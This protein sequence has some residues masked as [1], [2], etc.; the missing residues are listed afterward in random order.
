MATVSP[1]G[2]KEQTMVTIWKKRDDKII[3]SA[4]LEQSCWVQVTNPTSF[5]IESLEQEYLIPRDVIQDVLDVDERSRVEREDNYRGVII[6]VPIFSPDIRVPYYTVPLGIFIL[7]GLIITISMEEPSFLK[8]LSENRAR[9][10]DLGNPRNFVL[11]VFLGMSTYYLR[12]LKQINKQTTVIEQDLQRSVRNNELI[13]L[14]DVEK[15]LVYFTTSLKANEIVMDKLQR[16]YFTGMDEDLV[17]RLEDVLTEHRQAIDM[18]NIYSN[19]L[20]GMMDAFASVISNNLNV[21]M[22]R[23]TMISVVIMIPTFLASL[24]GMNVPLPFQGSNLAFYG[25]LAV[26]AVAAGVGAVI[27]GLRRISRRR[28]R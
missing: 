16:T 21:V 7:E 27:L 28:R 15:S 5:E 2:E 20:S 9:F 8:D 11:Q 18:A 10:T 4:I 26:S 14:L 22:K 24:Y 12:Y 3:R 1:T 13:R 6:R 23:L 25:I 19:I 17:D